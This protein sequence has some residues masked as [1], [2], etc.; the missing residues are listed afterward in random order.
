[1]QELPLGRGTSPGVLEE[2]S[3]ALAGP[4]GRLISSHTPCLLSDSFHVSLQLAEALAA[5]SAQCHRDFLHSSRFKG[6]SCC[7]SASATAVWSRWH[8][9]RAAA[10]AGP[11]VLST[12]QQ[13]S[14]F[15]RLIGF[16]F[17]L[18]DSNRK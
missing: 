8:H 4:N 6:S 2:P 13:L 10:P 16:C 12:R 18:N 1:M 17:L 14:S 15:F 3:G 5:W 7:A 11:G 9:S